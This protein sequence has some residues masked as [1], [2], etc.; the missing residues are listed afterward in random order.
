V[1]V[2]RGRNDERKRMTPHDGGRMKRNNPF[3]IL[4]LLNSPSLGGANR[5]LSI[6]LAGLDRTRFRPVAIIPTEGPFLQRLEE[7]DVPTHV[8]TLPS[9]SRRRTTVLGRS[10]GTVQHAW[11]LLRL[12]KLLKEEGVRIVH[13]NTIFPLGGAVVA[14]WSSLPHVWHLREGLDTPEYDLRF[15]RAA[16]RRIIGA[17]S[18]RMICISDYVR[19]VS[20]PARV[21][22]RA[23][24][25]PNALEEE[26]MA[27]VRG[28]LAAPNVGLVGLLGSKK[29]TSL[30]V[31]AAAAIARAFPKARFLVAGIPSAGE[32]GI[33]AE[34]RTRASLLGIEGRIEWLGFV[35]NLEAVYERIDLLLHP[36][37]HEAFGRVLIEALSRGVSFRPTIHNVW[38][39]R[40]SP[41]SP[42]R[43][44]T[45]PWPE[46]PGPGRSSASR[47]PPTSAVSPRSTMICW[48]RGRYEGLRIRK[49]GGPRRGG[50][51]GDWIDQ[52]GRPSFRGPPPGAPP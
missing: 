24:V 42:M 51:G 20:V 21:R 15:G 49:A 41:A 23:V 37:V 8:F 52:P 46:P 16:S 47:R 44:S 50:V 4:Y 34:C 27:H 12:R 11:N 39:R 43:T 48:V 6:V 26:P 22:D 31:E 2:V 28:S 18:D 13:T 40:P 25:I 29:R 45:T 5:S 1:R 14:K 19:R 3:T 38:P 10:K 35:D 30:F 36:G 33:V 17:L 7:F 32:E 9:L